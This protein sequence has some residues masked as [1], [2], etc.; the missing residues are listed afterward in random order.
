VGVQVVHGRLVWAVLP[1]P[2]DSPGR[3]APAQ[4]DLSLLVACRPHHLSQPRT[5]LRLP[6]SRVPRVLQTKR[7]AASPVPPVLPP[8]NLRPLPSSAQ[9]PF[10]A[11][12]YL[13]GGRSRGPPVRRAFPWADCTQAASLERPVRVGPRLHSLRWQACQATTFSPQRASCD[14]PLQPRHSLARSQRAFLGPTVPL[15]HWAWGVAVVSRAQPA[16]RALVH[17]RDLLPRALLR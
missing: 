14:Q 11:R 1:L 17:C 5:F 2:A 10:P 12:I 6:A 9:P 3:E 4:W 7:T 8:C 13:W 15:R 16:P